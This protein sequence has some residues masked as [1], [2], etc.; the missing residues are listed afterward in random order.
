MISIDIGGRNFSVARLKEFSSEEEMA[1]VK[2]LLADFSCPL[3]EEVEFFLRK[4]ALG[5]DE[6]NQAVTYLVFA[7]NK[8]VAYF[9]LANKL[10]QV[11]KSKISKTV[12]KRLLRTAEDSGGDFLNIPS[13]LVAQLGKNYSNGNNASIS[14]QDLLLI[15]SYF[16]REVQKYIG[17]AVYFLE[18]DSD[19]QK[20]IDFYKQNG[21]VFFSERRAKASGI[22]LLQFMKKI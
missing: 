9:T 21:F 6:R 1:A 17:G 16:V 22:K 3:N 2:A 11:Q 4:E 19:R 14:G 10:I 12:L 8:F 20:V 13:I 15:I 18:C 7:E 5:F